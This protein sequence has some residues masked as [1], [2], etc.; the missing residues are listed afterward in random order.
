MRGRPIPIHCTVVGQTRARVHVWRHGRTALGAT[1]PFRRRPLSRAYRPFI[2]PISL[3][4]SGQMLT[5]HSVIEI[6]EMLRLSSDH[7]FAV[8][9]VDEIGLMQ[10][11]ARDSG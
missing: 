7:S 2:E 10:R 5:P 6:V 3:G 11:H 8:L 4:S 9:T 1:Y